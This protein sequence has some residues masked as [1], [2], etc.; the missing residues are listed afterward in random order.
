MAA[1][2][3]RTT[4]NEKLIIRKAELKAGAP[5]MSGLCH[6]AY[7]RKDIALIVPVKTKSSV[8]KRIWHVSP[9]VRRVDT[10]L[11]RK[12]IDCATMQQHDEITDIISVYVGL[13]SFGNRFR[14]KEMEDIIKLFVDKNIIIPKCED[15]K[16][17]IN[18]SDLTPEKVQKLVA[19]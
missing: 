17:R 1:P 10:T 3:F 8:I 12:A 11:I 14:F 16:R 4:A 9:P 5:K 13:A 19:V 15:G 2:I 18:T 7:P 6:K